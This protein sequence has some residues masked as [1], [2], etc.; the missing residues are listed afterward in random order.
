MEVHSVEAVVR[1]LN[2][3]EVEYLIV[4]GLAVNAHGFVR[5]TRDI[6]I[7]IRLTPDNARNGL[8]ALLAIGYQMSIPEKPE[9]FA[10]APTRER[11][12]EEKQMV[13][14]KLWSDEH[15]RTPIDIF[16][17]EPFSFAEELGRCVLLEISPG[18]T[19]PVVA[20][21]TL[22]E[23]KRAVGRP[24]DLIDIQELERVR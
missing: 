1:A 23:M 12:R 2:S 6:D 17:Y 15:R 19:A 21:A 5:L 3:A 4:G 14:L 13:V 18:V 11:W 22:L 24:Q 7:V 10:D 16:V 8:H 9:A 20:L